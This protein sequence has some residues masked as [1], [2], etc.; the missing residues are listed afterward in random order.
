[1][2]K[3]YYLFYLTIISL[4]SF[5]SHAWI[6]DSIPH[7]ARD[8][9]SKYENSIHSSNLGMLSQICKAYQDGK[10]WKND[11]GNKLVECYIDE[12]KEA[13]FISISQNSIVEYL[14]YKCRKFL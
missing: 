6:F 7:N 14:T 4:I 13:D 5:N 9:L 2:L 12:L 1:M 11:K 3:K 8:C 10:V